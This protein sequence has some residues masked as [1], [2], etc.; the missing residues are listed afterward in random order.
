MRKEIE[1]VI[2]SFQGQERFN[3]LLGLELLDCSREGLWAEY[4]FN[5]EEWCKNPSGGV[6]GGVI[7]SLFDTSTG[8]TAVG[9]SEM[10]VTTTDMSV[11]FVRPMNGNRYIF[12]AECSHQGK[13]MLRLTGKAFDAETGELC[14][15]AMASFM[16]IGSREKPLRV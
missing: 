1:E 16:V 15:T 6:H 14:A 11:S 5:V 3:K 9:L 8:I 2:E 13:R 7:C 4:A 12:R 10:N